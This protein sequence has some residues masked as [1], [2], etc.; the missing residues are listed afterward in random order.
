MAG[1]FHGQRTR[2]RPLPREVATDWCR[3]AERLAEIEH[4]PGMG[5]HS[6]RRKFVNDLKPTTNLL[7]LAY[8][9]GWKSPVTVLTVYPQPDLELQL[10]SLAGRNKVGSV[11]QSKTN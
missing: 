11:P 3:E 10:A 2:D 4:V 9:G 1:F 7:D 5:F 8:M 6:V